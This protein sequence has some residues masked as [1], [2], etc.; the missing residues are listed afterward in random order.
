LFRLAIPVLFLL[1]GALAF[2]ALVRSLLDR[3]VLKKH[4]KDLE[5]D[6]YCSLAWYVRQRFGY[7]KDPSNPIFAEFKWANIFRTRVELDD[8]LFAPK[9]RVDLEELLIEK[10][11]NDDKAEVIEDAVALARSKQAS[12]LP[13]Y[14]GG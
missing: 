3:S 7:F 10:L 11:D 4:V 8:Q 14:A 9:S 2:A 12:G 5:N 1:H 13:S 6:P